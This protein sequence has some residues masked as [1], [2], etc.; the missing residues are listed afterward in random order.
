MGYY[1]EKKLEEA[2]PEESDGY[3][4]AVNLVWTIAAASDTLRLTKLQPHTDEWFTAS[5][6]HI[7]APWKARW[8]QYIIKS[9]PTRKIAACSQSGNCASGPCPS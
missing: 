6:V 8:I 7:G 1:K 2:A 3:K 9:D 4:L 5:Y